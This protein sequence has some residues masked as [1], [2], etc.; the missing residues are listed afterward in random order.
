[1]L[2]NAMKLRLVVPTG[3]LYTAEHDFTATIALMSGQLAGSSARGLLL[4]AIML[5]CTGA[6]GDA[7]ERERRLA[8]RLREAVAQGASVNLATRR[9]PGPA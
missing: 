1:M 6:G 9:L 2:A 8:E 3:R 5:F 7:G 4:A